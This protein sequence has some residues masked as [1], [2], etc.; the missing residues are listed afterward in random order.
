L[1]NIG[2]VRNTGTQNIGF[3]RNIGTQG[4]SRFPVMVVGV[5]AKKKGNGGGRTTTDELMEL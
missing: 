5:F 1:E 3:V 2:F 4:N